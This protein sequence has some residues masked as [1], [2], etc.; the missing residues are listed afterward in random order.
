MAPLTIPQGKGHLSASHHSH[1]EVY[2]IEP[3][4]DSNHHQAPLGHH[5]QPLSH[6]PP[7]S[8]SNPLLSHPLPTTGDGGMRI[9]MALT[10]IWIKMKVP[11]RSVSV[12]IHPRRNRKTLSSLLLRSRRHTRSQ[13]GRLR[14]GWTWR[15]V[16]ERSACQGCWKEGKGWQWEQSR[17]HQWR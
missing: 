14:R 16:E 6:R 5:P 7:P 2:R 4:Q 10:S 9:V 17:K 13:Q 11:S 12:W 8:K 3:T 1:P 15:W